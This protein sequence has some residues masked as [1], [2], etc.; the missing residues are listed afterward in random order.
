MNSDPCRLWADF[1]QNEEAPEFSAPRVTASLGIQPGVLNSKRALEPLLCT[2][3]GKDQAF[4]WGREHCAMARLPF[5][6]T[7][8]TQDMMFAARWTV[9]SQGQ[10]RDLR[11]TFE[12]A[13]SE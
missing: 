9:Q 8:C 5:D 2:G 11:S 6:D 3:L 13:L 1:K 10:A 4:R 12:G 7:P